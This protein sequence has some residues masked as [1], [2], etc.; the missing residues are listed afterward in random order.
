MF[1]WILGVFVMF[2]EELF[3]YRDTWDNNFTM[4]F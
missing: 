3:K 4:R 2:G 1:V